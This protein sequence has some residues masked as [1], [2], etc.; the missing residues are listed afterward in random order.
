L[1]GAFAAQDDL[2]IIS[3]DGFAGGRKT[4]CKGD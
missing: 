1:V 4:V 3:Q 2:E